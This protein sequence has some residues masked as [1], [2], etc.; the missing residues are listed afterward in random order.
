MALGSTNIRLVLRLPKPVDAATIAENVT[1]VDLGVSP[2][3]VVPT[4]SI[5]GTSS[6]YLPGCVGTE[7]SINV[8]LIPQDRSV[9]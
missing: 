7:E 3:A 6:R 4:V 1:L 8:T 5:T 2:P 9:G